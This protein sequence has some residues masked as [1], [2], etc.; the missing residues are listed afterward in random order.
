MDGLL[1]PVSTSYRNSSREVEPALVEVTKP[2]EQVGKPGFQA[3]SPAEAL[4]ILKNEPDYDSLIST[5]RFLCQENGSFNIASPSPI[6]AQLVH[7]L[8]SEI[9]PNYWDILRNSPQKNSSK[10]SKPKSDLQLLLSCLRNVS[11]L[12]AILLGLKQRIQQSKDTEKVAGGLS[13]QDILR[14]LLQILQ[15]VL[16]GTK[17]VKAIWE[18][19]YVSSE[20]TPRENSVWQEFVSLAA[21]GRLL[22]ISAEAEDVLN[23][24]SKK[25]GEKHWIAD[26]HLYGLWLA[27]NIS[28]W[29]AFL[30][31]DSETAFTSCG[32]LLNKSFRLG[33]TGMGGKRFIFRL[34]LIVSQKVSSRSW[35]IR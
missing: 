35:W 25:I 14:I 23:A 5:L 21:G 24:A 10:K 28:N 34:L 16:K 4:E 1:T 7:I 29:A 30:P 20:P 9:V 6:A 22:G 33:H 8:V 12:S 31:V 19:I 3:S 15:A 11:G 17:T 13:I 32:S 2:R 26:S 18:S 27:Q